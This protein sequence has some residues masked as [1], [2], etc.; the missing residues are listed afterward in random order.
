MVVAVGVEPGLLSWELVGHIEQLGGDLIDTLVNLGPLDD[1]RYAAILKVNFIVLM[2][3]KVVFIVLVIQGLGLITHSIGV[4]V[5]AVEN[6]YSDIEGVV[7]VQVG[8]SL[9]LA[10]LVS[11]AMQVECSIVVDSVNSR[12]EQFVLGQVQLSGLF[13]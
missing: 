1:C 2:Q 3:A 11:V 9:T 6:R 7:Q 13:N 10:A 4:L 5:L 8:E 12:T